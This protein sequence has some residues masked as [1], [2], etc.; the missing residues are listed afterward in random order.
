MD[1]S[2]PG[3]SVHGISQ[4]RILQWV[5]IS[6]YMGSSQPRIEPMS[7]ALVGVFFTTVPLG[8]P[9]VLDT[10]WVF[11][12]WMKVGKL[13]ASW[14]NNLPVTFLLNS[15]TNTVGCWPTIPCISLIISLYL[16]CNLIQWPELMTLLW[17]FALG[18][19]ESESW[20]C[21]WIAQ[22]QGLT[23]RKSSGF[24]SIC[25]YNFRFCGFRGPCS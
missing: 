14:N 16:S 12:E 8:S 13:Q 19:L 20:K 3:S 7:P 17:K 1:C 4:A 25:P 5:A 21:V 10:F 18:L 6:S 11:I 9:T 15:I 22:S 24:M 23:Y 2:L